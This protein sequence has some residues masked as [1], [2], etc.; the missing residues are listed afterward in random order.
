MSVAVK[1]PVES[2]ARPE[3]ACSVPSVPG[4]SWSFVSNEKFGSSD[5]SFKFESVA[6]R[7]VS[8]G[9]KDV[10]IG[11]KDGIVGSIGGNDES[12][13]GRAVSMAGRDL[14]IGGREV[15]RL[16]K[17]ASRSTW[18][19]SAAGASFDSP[20]ALGGSLDGFVGSVVSAIWDH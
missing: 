5:K 7:V 16:W 15:S 3:T 13:L 19:G 18:L 12:I 17:V 8:N 1:S 10:S 9:G 4:S 2:P 20:T 11:G 14:S 6:G